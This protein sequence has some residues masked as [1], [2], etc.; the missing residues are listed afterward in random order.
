MKLKETELRPQ[1]PSTLKPRNLYLDSLRGLA[2]YLVILGHA[3]SNFTMSYYQGGFFWLDP[4]HIAIY[5][6]HMPLFALISGYLFVKA[7]DERNP[8]SFASRKLPNLLVPWIIWGGITWCVKAIQADTGLFELKLA[9]KHIIGYYWFITTISIVMLLVWAVYRYLRYP[10]VV[11]LALLLALQL[12]PASKI[13]MYD[14]LRIKETAFL[15]P[16]FV[17][18]LECNKH[19]EKCLFLFERYRYVFLSGSILAFAI[20]FSI[21]D[22]DTYIYTS[23]VSLFDSSLGVLGQVSVN[24]SRW[25]IGALGSFLVAYLVYLL[26]ST[27][28][29]RMLAHLGPMS[30]GVYLLQEV[31]LTYGVR[32]YSLGQYIAYPSVSIFVISIV[33]TLLCWG[34]I[35]LSSR[36]LPKEWKLYIFGR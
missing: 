6:F 12:L 18:G 3:M 14:F 17:F 25:A 24:L 22:K 27:T 20:L 19:Q 21:Y 4:W 33:V 10:W 16:F 26:R 32:A 36:F 7:L 8:W 29:I 5:S 2:V 13:P 9:L 23:G 30:L 1:S 35:R 28:I 31:L 34:I 15:L 11:F